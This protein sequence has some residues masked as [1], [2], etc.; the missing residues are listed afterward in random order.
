MAKEIMVPRMMRN[1]SKKMRI[2]AGRTRNRE[3]WQLTG[4]KAEMS[5]WS[6]NEKYGV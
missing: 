6:R 5:K 1:H 4:L 3:E 2:K